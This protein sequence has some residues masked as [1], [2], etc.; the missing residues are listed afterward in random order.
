MNDPEMHPQVSTG[1][2]PDGVERFAAPCGCTFES[3]D[4]TKEFRIRPCSETC[5]YYAYFITES[6]KQGK[7]IEMRKDGGTR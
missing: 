2:D 7:P 5:T 6:R 4:T 1:V 3:D